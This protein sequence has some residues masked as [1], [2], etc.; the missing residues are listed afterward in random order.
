MVI[1]IYEKSRRQ[2][3]EICFSP[4]RNVKIRSFSLLGTIGASPPTDRVTKL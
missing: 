4:D 3:Y 1:K 2:T